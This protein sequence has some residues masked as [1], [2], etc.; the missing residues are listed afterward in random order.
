M[1]EGVPQVT[2]AGH[3][4]HRAMSAISALLRVDPL[5]VG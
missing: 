4:L 3:L 5:L 2:L 1:I